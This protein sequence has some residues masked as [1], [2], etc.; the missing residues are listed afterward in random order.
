MKLT[1]LGG[2][3]M[4]ARTLDGIDQEI[5]ALLVVRQLLRTA[6]AD[7]TSTQYGTDPD[8]ASFST[9]WQ[10]ARDLVIRPRASSPT[11]SSTSSAPSFDMS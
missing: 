10:T 7:A 4:R 1:I 5:Y 6:M 11:R 8:R 9:V 3:V 2:R